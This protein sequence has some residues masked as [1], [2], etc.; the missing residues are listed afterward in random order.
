[1][2][3]NEEK[4]IYYHNLSL[5]TNRESSRRVLEILDTLP[6]RT[7]TNY[8]ETAILAHHQMET[9]KEA[10]LEFMEEHMAH[11]DLLIKEAL[12]EFMKSHAA[13]FDLTTEEEKPAQP[14]MLKEET[15]ASAKS[16]PQNK[17]NQAKKR[18]IDPSVLNGFV[19]S[20][21]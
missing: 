11:F 19:N 18:E 21:L 6:E 13:H 17:P 15:S 14:V 3:S 9:S 8:I 16:E 10:L 4:T 1:M 12:L 5:N 20:I 2:R 7:R